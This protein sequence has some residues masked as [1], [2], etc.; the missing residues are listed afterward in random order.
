MQASQQ[1]QDTQNPESQLLTEDEAEAILIIL[2]TREQVKKEPYPVLNLLLIYN[3]RDI[4][5]LNS[6]VP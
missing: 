4:H 1:K 3:I 6:L 5:H 2:W